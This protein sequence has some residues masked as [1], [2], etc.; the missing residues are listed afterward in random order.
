MNKIKNL[1]ERIKKYL[2]S[3]FSKQG[4]KLIEANTSN[5]Q[6]EISFNEISTK[7][8]ETEKDDF[9]T[10]YKNVKNGA[11]KITD[12]MINDLI[13]VQLMMQKEI[14]IFDEKIGDA[15]DEILRLDA[16]ISMLEK[17]REMYVKKLQKTN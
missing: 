4:I 16:E 8:I 13:Q 14:G 9:F 11:I 10:V 15:E 17:D 2:N 3:L 5:N 7:Y 1:L 6:E 12:L